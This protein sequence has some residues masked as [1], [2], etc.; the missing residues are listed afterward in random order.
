MIFCSPPPPVGA[1]LWISS[2]LREASITFAIR[3]E[4]CMSVCVCVCVCVLK[5]RGNREDGKVGQRS[6]NCSYF[7]LAQNCD[8]G[9]SELS[10]N[11]EAKVLSHLPPRPSEAQ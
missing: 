4:M 5:A 6:W 10:Q 3:K 2:V 8:L 7:N 1:F 9:S 11:D